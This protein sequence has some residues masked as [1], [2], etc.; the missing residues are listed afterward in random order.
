MGLGPNFGMICCVKIQFFK[1]AFPV[2][3]GIACAKDAS[4][5]DNLELLD[6]SNQ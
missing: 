6:G 3:F 2:L 4:V 5:A 1:E